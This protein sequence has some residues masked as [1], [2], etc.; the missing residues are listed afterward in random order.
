[1]PETTGPD[2]PPPPA[3]GHGAESGAEFAGTRYH[4]IRFHAR[5]GL[6]EVYVAED[7]ELNRLVAYKQIQE[8]LRD[9]PV[10]RIRFQR[11][12]EVTAKLEHP[13][14][15][16]VYGLVFNQDG[17]PS[18]AM[19]FIEGESLQ[20]AIVL[21]HRATLLDEDENEWN[22]GL[23]RLINRF[24]AVC[25]TVAFAHNKG[26]LHRDIKPQNIMIG[27][28]GETL[29]I[30]WGLAKPFAR[31][32]EE[33]S[34]GESSLSLTIPLASAGEVADASTQPD[35]VLGTPAFMSPEQASGQQLR[36]TSD[37]FSLGATLYAILVNQAPYTGR[38]PQEVLQ[39]AA[40]TKF[41][42]PRKLNPAIPCPL[43]AICLKAMASDPRQR[44]QTALDLAKDLENWLAN[45][46]VLAYKESLAAAASRWCR[47]HMAAAAL[48]CVLFVLAVRF[49]AFNVLRP[50]LNPVVGEYN[51]ELIGLLGD[52]F[53][54]GIQFGAL[55]GL[56]LG[57]L[58][59]TFRYSRGRK[60]SAERFSNR[61]VRWIAWG[62]F[63]GMIYGFILFFI[64]MVSSRGEKNADRLEE[65]R[66]RLNKMPAFP[67]SPSQGR[68]RPLPAVPRPVP[69]AGPA[70]RGPG[71]VP[72][73][74]WR[75][76]NHWLERRPHSL[77]ALPAARHPR[78][79]FRPVGG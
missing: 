37:I 40:E 15:V 21:L 55:L 38:T 52:V 79:G 63:T 50:V 64:V 39:N 48:I 56:M 45:G 23:R 5:G 24:V 14:I 10:H 17:H 6:G 43:E 72:L 78:R 19:R 49:A 70:P 68:P 16:P 62:A 42:R 73:S 67:F 20:D 69:P 4:P 76:D 35:R 11:E 32:E 34:N 44:Y 61:V 1:M 47:K 27:K 58:I 60:R 29:I 13:G 31:G 75:C 59:V 51:S 7:L 74:G 46:P 65:I 77:A 22:L 30:D 71:N 33:R 57:V 28:F 12:A 2:L 36:S 9:N 8:H 54:R 18:Y 53:F 3:D 26:I 66:R 41:Q 25:N